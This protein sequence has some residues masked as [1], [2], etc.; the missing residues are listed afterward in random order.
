MSEKLLTTG[1]AAEQLGVAR[2]TVRSWL[3]TGIL[4]GTKVGGGRLWRISESTI[5]QFIKD[6]HSNNEAVEDY[7]QI[8]IRAVEQ[9]ITARNKA[10]AVMEKCEDRQE[11]ALEIANDGLWDWNLSDNTIYYD[12]RYYRMSGYEPN[13]FPHTFEQWAKRVHPDDLDRCSAAIQAHL[14]GETAMFDIEFRFRRK[15][16]TWM[17]IRGRGKIVKR[18][19]KGI[20]LRLL[21]THEDITDRKKAE[22]LLK[23]EQRE[24]ELIL[25][26]LAEQVAFL[27]PGMHIIWVN[28]QVEVRH[29]IRP[30][31]YMGRKC[32]EVYH[33]ISEPC[34]DCP[35][36]DVF[37]TGVVNSGIHR[38]P[39]GTYWKVTGMP[40]FDEN[41]SLIGA[42]DTA[43][44][45]TELKL[46]EEAL[47]ESERKYREILE[48]MED[49]YYEVDLGGS[50]I[51]CNKAAARM[52]GYEEEEL[53]GIN[54]SSLCKDTAS[55]YRFFNE[56]F[57]SNKAKFS[58]ILEMIRKDGSIGHADVSL[59]L[60]YD[61]EGNIIGFRGLGRDIT[62]RIQFEKELKRL[63][64]HDQLTGLYN[65]HY[66]V[67]ELKRL[68]GSR[69]YPIAIISADLDGLKK[70]ND[71]LGHKEGDLYLKASAAL[72]KETLRGYDLLTR[73][74]GDEFA[75]VLP[76]TD[77]KAGEEILNRLNRRVEEYNIATKKDFPLSIS[78]GLA[79]SESAAQPLEET[80]HLADRFMYENRL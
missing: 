42:I 71:T 25:D 63:S 20:A 2:A 1:D 41:G 10:E 45:I 38:S 73:V 79:V 75:L 7:E 11:L 65:R 34:P 16:E 64:F 30:E 68:E 19:D 35:V 12:A 56:A 5:E 43:L 49:G 27:D 40:V 54:Y 4:K 28:R 26:N 67:N 32:Y 70:I 47:R 37:K 59:S 66:F 57:K 44:E 50:I 62:E 60:T 18:D 13:E 24:K 48:T 29:N 58:L 39:D 23:K 76:R 33:Q 17:W 77:K 72:F 80:Y 31:D 6:D 15:D 55:V 74:G 22:E 36:I 61:R 46:A 21:G 52:L 51:A 3:R 14:S 9:D 78:L 69:E 53:I 8:L